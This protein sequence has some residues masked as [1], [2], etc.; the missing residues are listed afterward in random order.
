M[1]NKNKRIEKL[2]VSE[3]TAYEVSELVFAK[4]KGFPY[5]PARITSIFGNRYRVTFFGDNTTYVFLY[6]LN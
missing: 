5:W 1:P 2:A 4:V 3:C 6:Y